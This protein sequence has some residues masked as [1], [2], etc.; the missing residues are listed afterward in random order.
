MIRAVNISRIAGFTLIEVMVTL[1]IAAILAT[2]AAPMLS[3]FLARSQMNAV[4]NDLTGALQM[5]RMEAVSR[6]TCVSIC[7]RATSGAAQCAGDEGAWSSGWLVYESPSCD[8]AVAVTD[9]PAD[10]TL[11]AR[12][13]VPS[14]IS[15]NTSDGTAPAV[16]G[17]TPRGVPLSAAFAF[18]NGTIWLKDSRFAD[19]SLDRQVVLSRAGRVVTRAGGDAGD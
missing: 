5:A 16:I 4:A 8:G 6:N 15:V 1:A 19:G 14:S 3:G 17:F 18:T 9:P 12:E 13:A 2:M 10:K 11:R 7:R